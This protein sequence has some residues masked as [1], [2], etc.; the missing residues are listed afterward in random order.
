MRR[1]RRLVVAVMLL[2]CLWGVAL[3]RSA[4]SARSIMNTMIDPS[5][6]R[7]WRSVSTI[8]TA[9]GVREVY[10]RTDK[11]W[12]D[13]RKVASVLAE[14]GTLLKNEPPPDADED[15]DKWSDAIVDAAALTIKA[16][17]ARNPTRVLE[18]GEK[19]YDTCVGCHG[20]Y[21]LIMAAP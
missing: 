17:D 1:P 9:D 18:A 3:A 16:V 13:L 20:G 11:E 12:K 2:S 10:P 6:I 4:A 14:G 7:I 19:I 21:S 8:V 15:W 5:A